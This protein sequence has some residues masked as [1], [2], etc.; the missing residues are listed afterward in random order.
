MLKGV[1]EAINKKKGHK[2][3]ILNGYPDRET[4]NYTAS[5]YVLAITAALNRF[6]VLRHSPRKYITHMIW[7]EGSKVPVNED[8]LRAQ[9]IAC[10]RIARS[11]ACAE[12]TPVYDEA[13][14]VKCLA[15]LCVDC[16]KNGVE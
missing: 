9:G 13:L 3:L 4:H 8:A 7:V 10:V 2:V 1:G 5:D 11:P 15:D 14:L 12:D 6:G 16:G